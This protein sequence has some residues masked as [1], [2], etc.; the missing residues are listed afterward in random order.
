MRDGIKRRP[1][2][3]VDAARRRALAQRMR[4]LMD[5]QGLSVTEI[6]RRMEKELS[7]EKFN[8][9]NLSHYKAGRSLPRPRYLNALSRAFGVSSEEL[10]PPEGAL[11]LLD[12]EPLG[13]SDPQAPAFRIED[14]SDGLAWLQINQKLPWP[15]VLRILDALKGDKAEGRGPGGALPPG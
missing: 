4:K 7:G 3:Q 10:L 1:G 6:A 11:E 8:P 14:L 13:V 2:G 9:V 5:E 12:I 15:L